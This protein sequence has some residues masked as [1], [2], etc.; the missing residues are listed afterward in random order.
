IAIISRNPDI[1]IDEIQLELYTQHGFNVSIATIHC[2][3]KQ[4]GYSSKKLTWIAAERQRSRQLI[5]FQEIGRVPP[6]YLV[7]GD[8]SA[9]NI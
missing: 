3:L 1:Y 9:I 5:Y 2:S 8:E 6:E 7:F 4:L